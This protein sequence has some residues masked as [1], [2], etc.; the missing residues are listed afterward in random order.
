[1]EDDN[2]V[3]HS[4]FAQYTLSSNLTGLVAFDQNLTARITLSAQTPGAQVISVT[5]FN[6]QDFTAA[7]TVLQMSAVFVPYF[8]SA[9]YIVYPQGFVTIDSPK[10][11]YSTSG[12]YASEDEYL[13][14]LNTYGTGIG[15]AFY[16]EGHTEA[17][18]LSA[19]TLNTGCSASWTVG[20][21]NVVTN[22][23]TTSAAVFSESKVAAVYPTSLQ[24]FNNTFVQ[25]GPV[26]A[27]YESLSGIPCYYPFYSSSIAAS[28]GDTPNNTTFHKSLSVLTYPQPTR[29]N[30]TFVTTPS[31]SGNVISLPLDSS[32]QLF[33]AFFD[34][35][36]YDNSLFVQQYDG[37]VW[38]VNATAN[39]AGVNP[40]W[41]LTTV[42]LSSSVKNFKFQLSYSDQYNIDNVFLRA[43]AGYQTNLNLQVSGYKIISLQ[44]FPGQSNRLTPSRDWIPRYQII[45]FTTSTSIL[46]LPVT[47]LYVANYYNLTGTN[48]LFTNV[49]SNS[50]TQAT[51]A[52]TTILYRDLSSAPLSGGQSDTFFFKVSDLGM[53][54]LSATTTFI[55]SSY[56]SYTKTY[57][58]PGIFEVVEAFDDI[59]TQH[60]RSEIS[61]LVLIYNTAPRLTPNEWVTND[62]V[63]NLIDKFTVAI[64]ELDQYTSLYTLS[65]TKQ[66]GRLEQRYMQTGYTSSLTLSAYTLPDGSITTY[67]Y[68]I[69]ID[70]FGTQLSSLSA[71]T[72]F[73]SSLTATVSFP[74]FEFITVP[75]LPGLE[76]KWVTPFIDPNS[77]YNWPV[78]S[79]SSSL[80]YRGLIVL[81]KSKKI[82]TGYQ[83]YINLINN[84]YASRVLSTANSIDDIFEF[85]NIQSVQ[86][87]SQDYVVVLDSAFPRVSVYTI[88]NDQFSLFTTWGNF[89][90][91]S[92][93]LGFNKPQD[94]HI[95]QQDLIW[96]ADTGNNCIK[97]FTINGKNLLVIIHE[98]LNINA[99]ISVCVDSQ[100]HVHALTKGG[101]F[102][103][104]SEGTYLFDYSLPAEI[105]GASKINTSYNRESIYIVH[106]TGVIKYFRT[107]VIYQYT[108][109]KLSLNDG[110]TLQGF[111][112]IHQDQYRN[113]YITAKDQVIRIAD[114]MKLNRHRAQTIEQLLWVSNE[115]YEHKEEYVQPWVYLKSFHRLWDNIEL[116]RNS[117]FYN[118]TTRGSYV[119]PTYAKSELVIGQNEIVTNAVIN[120]ICDQL[121]TNL[122]S[123]ISFFNVVNVPFVPVVITPK[124]TETP[125]PTIT[126]TV[127]PT[128]TPT[129]TGTLPAD[130]IVDINDNSIYMVDMNDTTTYLVSGAKII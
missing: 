77:Y 11:R 111:A 112:S 107:G 49:W 65:T 56:N 124:P 44:N 99:P 120:R 40:D 62:N 85:Q 53:V 82:V 28:G 100:Q 10:Y 128:V 3:K 89:G 102:V 74:I 78:P 116:F 22:S 96:V 110:T 122:R 129:P 27:Y 31:I 72:T 117:L 108:V 39:P 38:N 119:P 47:N 83:N 2:R 66:T 18:G 130:G 95:D 6:D 7:I 5:A 104:D 68:N 71:I 123:I 64:N 19:K 60:Y 36:V 15:N 57:H 46:P 69:P 126:P 35:P 1:V 58:A 98:Y 30:Y 54:D 109:D 106:N 12:Q 94:L 103:F 63:N 51:P 16:G 13:V 115:L 114:L 41:S 88:N 52:S 9:D 76:Y 20:P 101:V 86:A 29:S 93:K 125:T 121:W 25:N 21:Y 43:S 50:S 113:L 45:P 23:R 81:P 55:D 97:K 75:V 118:E 33:T 48:V 8:L 90:Y 61:P 37:S 70:T 14:D 79:L 34:H 105:Q 84:S 24:I 80:Y 127:T 26:V 92:S 4:Y 87:T 91:A 17:I 73:G 42:K 67:G 59:E 32:R